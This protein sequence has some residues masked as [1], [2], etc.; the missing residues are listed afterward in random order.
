MATPAA[1][2]QRT[3]VEAS[4]VPVAV[5]S[6]E[7]AAAL[8]PIARA[9]C[10]GDTSDAVMTAVLKILKV[11]VAEWSA[12]RLSELTVSELVGG[13]QG[14]VPLKCTVSS[15]SS[16]ATVVFKL[17]PPDF[18]AASSAEETSLSGVAYLQF[19]QA[20][21]VPTAYCMGDARLPG[22][23]ISGFVE[24]GNAGGSDG[25]AGPDFLHDDANAASFG[26]L[27]GTIHAGVAVGDW[28]TPFKDQQQEWDIEEMTLSAEPASFAPGIQALLASAKSKGSSWADA[29]TAI[30]AMAQLLPALEGLLEPESLLG[31]SV[32]GHGD[33][34]GRNLMH[35]TN[36]RTG[37]L[38]TVDLVWCPQTFQAVVRSNCCSLVLLARHSL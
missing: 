16:P 3:S 32:F 37:D 7:E 33:V 27:L 19:S 6:Y 23:Q 17:P 38:I 22:V 9:A 14:T 4:A 10:K 1:K 15:C 25:S 26:A 21:V 11:A 8:I 2:K 36:A 34:H 35:S 28:Y 12:V 20:G 18:G 13:L 30:A 29:V 31:R 5:P 24:G